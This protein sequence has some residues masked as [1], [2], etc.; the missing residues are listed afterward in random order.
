MLKIKT[1]MRPYSTFDYHPAYR[2]CPNH[3]MW[4][5]AGCKLTREKW[6]WHWLT[7]FFFFNYMCVSQRLHLME[8]ETFYCRSIIRGEHR[9][10]IILRL[11]LQD[12]VWMSKMARW[13]INRLSCRCPTT[14]LHFPF[15][16]GHVKFFWAHIQ[17]RSWI[18]S[19]DVHSCEVNSFNHRTFRLLLN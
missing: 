11:R 7:F 9:S 1:I 18:S 16:T 12:C 15:P 6:Y 14:V 10:Y 8:I 2:C 5:Y 13:A 17:R 4:H 3:Y 19:H